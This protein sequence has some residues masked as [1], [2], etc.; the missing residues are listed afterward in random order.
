MR[1]LLNTLF[2][3]TEDAY[4]SLELENVVAKVDGKVVTKI[5]LR[6]LDSIVSFSYMGIS[7]ALL[8]YCGEIGVSVSMYSPRGKYYCSVLGE[9]NRN[10]LL[11]RQQYRMADKDDDC[12]A[13]ASMM[14]L[15][16]ISNARSVVIRALRDHPLS[17]SK[18]RVSAT[19]LNL[20]ESLKNVRAVSC[21]DELRGI[22]GDAAREYFSV[23]DDLILQGKDDFFFEGRNR[24]PPLDRT[25]AMLSFIYTLLA[26]DC[27][28]ALSGSGLD[29]YVGFL[30][31]DRPGRP[32][33][34]LDLMEELRPVLA[35][36]F[37]LTM[38]NNRVIRPNNFVQM[39]D[40]A[41]LLNDDGRKKVLAEWQQRKKDIITHPYLKEKVE[42]GLVPMVQ[43]LLLARYIRGDID[44]YPTFFWK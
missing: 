43:S 17:V 16:K 33:L 21:T 10:V 11:R 24:R 20:A 25:N 7:P 31:T 15:G 40:G 44:A 32:S 6:G 38:I 23:F 39:E 29:P 35:D 22:E 18:D 41:V 2:V 42:W 5:P 27:Q 30:H 8:G 19:V 37:V 9:N 14:L 28:A 13:V 3:T 12:C 4:L 36:R 34:A 26:R 1:R